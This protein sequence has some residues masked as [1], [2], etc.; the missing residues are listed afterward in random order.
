MILRLLIQDHALINNGQKLR[1]LKAI[2]LQMKEDQE[3][4][5]INRLSYRLFRKKAF[6]ET[7]LV[8]R[9]YMEEIMSLKNNELNNTA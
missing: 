3:K 5:L 1:L 7:M 9:N 6:H 4:P 2:H 8:D